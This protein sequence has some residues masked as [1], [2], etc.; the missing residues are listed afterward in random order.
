MAEPTLQLAPSLQLAPPQSL[1]LQAPHSATMSHPNVVVAATHAPAMTKPSRPH[2]AT[3]TMGVTSE[4]LSEKG[5]ESC[6]GIVASNGQNS[7]SSVAVDGDVCRDYLR[8]VC[9]R[10]RRCKYKHP[11]E[12]G[13]VVATS[14]TTT[15]TDQEVDLVTSVCRRTDLNFCHDFQNA[16]CKRPQCK[17]IHCSREEE[18]FF[19]TTG[20]LPARVQQMAVLAAAGS[21][22]L[23]LNKA[24][25]PPICKDFLKGQCKRAN[26]CK[27]RHVAGSSAVA[28]G[29]GAPE[30]VAAGVPS[31]VQLELAQGATSITNHGAGSG[32]EFLSCPSVADWITYP[33]NWTPP[34]LCWQIRCVVVCLMCDWSSRKMYCY[35]V[36]STSCTSSPRT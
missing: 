32:M 3:P 5:D 34:C 30:M 15:S 10:G 22:P 6:E 8:N 20:Q 36:R 19:R 25:E 16:G 29:T 11:A 28:N 13:N 4:S 7:P 14:G 2:S 27:F 33:R 31:P 21:E 17:F 9:K 24:G 23:L 26:K 12:R 18:E 1:Q 35:G